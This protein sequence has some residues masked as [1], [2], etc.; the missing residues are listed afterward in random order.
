MRMLAMMHDAERR[1]EE[2]EH[3]RAGLRSPLA[4]GA[5]DK[6][7]AEGVL[8]DEL[9]DDELDEDDEDDADVRELD[10]VDGFPS[11]PT[12]AR[13]RRRFVKPAQTTYALSFSRRHALARRG[14]AKAQSDDAHD[15][16]GRNECR[17]ALPGGAASVSSLSSVLTE[18]MT[19]K[20]TAL[21]NIVDTTPPQPD[22]SYV[23]RTAADGTPYVAA[24]DGSKYFENSTIGQIFLKPAPNQAGASSRGRRSDLDFLQS[25]GWRHQQQQQLQQ[26]QPTRR[27]D[28]VGA[29]VASSTSAQGVDV[30]AKKGSKPLLGFKGFHIGK[31]KEKRTRPV[32]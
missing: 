27:S 19:G 16:G 8:D 2:H 24:S 10:P 32:T 11:P 15:R 6:A 18:V 5:P 26:Q 23:V 29:E 17:P 14:R 25:G 30:D 3:G 21:N 9:D 13:S 7:G 4:S 12:R 22:V 28:F 1:R 31:K 20:T